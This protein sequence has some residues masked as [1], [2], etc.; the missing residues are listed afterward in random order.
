MAGEGAEEHNHTFTDRVIPGCGGKA[1]ANRGQ[2]KGK[3]DQELTASSRPFCTL[4]IHIPPGFILPEWLVVEEA[5][6]EGEHALGMGTP[7]VIDDSHACTDHGST[8]LEA[9]GQGKQVFRGRLGRGDEGQ[10]Y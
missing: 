1:Q 5:L 6:K 7:V 10:C 4:H 2:K 8:D 3:G 9:Q